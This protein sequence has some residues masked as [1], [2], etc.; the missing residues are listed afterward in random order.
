M[1]DISLNRSGTNQRAIKVLVLGGGSDQISLISQL[2]KLGATI[3]LIDYYE[4]P[5]AKDYA[6]KHYKTSTMD[7]E[8]VISIAQNEGV[9][10]VITACID[11]ALLSM[12]YVTEKLG[13]FCPLSYQQA[14]NVTNKS[15]MKDIMLKNSIPTSR[16]T[17]I[18][19]GEH[20]C[21]EGFKYPLVVKPADSNGSFGVKKVVNKNEL[22]NYVLNAL[23]ISR[24]GQAIIEEFQEGMEISVD[25]FIKNAEAELLM[26]T[27]SRKITNAN[28][29]FPIYQSRYP[30]SVS[31]N[32]KNEIKRI[33]N[34]IARAF[35][36]DNTPLLIQVICVDDEFGKVS[37]IEFGARIAG[38]SKHHLIKEV[39]GFDI[40]KAY[41]DSFFG[42]DFDVKVSPTINHVSMNY[43]YA[44]PGVFQKIE[45]I[46]EL[47]NEGILV[48]YY[49]YK[50]PGMTVDGSF[51][52]RDRICSFMVKGSTE[53]EMDEKLRRAVNEIQIV[54]NEN[55][56]FML[57]D[58]FE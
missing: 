2:R 8:A 22:E 18:K 20:C 11:Q 50:T 9:D 38:G 27:T 57:R 39:T 58:I 23:K 4:N 47:K 17:V 6:D 42:I 3:V 51:A 21:L 41:V 44:R 26:M 25:V 52:S 54:N 7:M 49:M 53:S 32:T 43:V 40:M 5:P 35:N 48:D 31:K 14:L 1:S 36:L 10:Y 24:S 30:V 16:H 46:D 29:G 13:L 34:Q 12:A 56:D 55:N 19:S 33:A 45:N 15:Y 28:S 37:V